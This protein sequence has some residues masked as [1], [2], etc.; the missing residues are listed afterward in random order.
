MTELLR[1]EFS[2]SSY[3]ARPHCSYKYAEALLSL[4]SNLF[5]K[6]IPDENNKC[7]KA[8][9]SLNSSLYPERI[10]DQSQVTTCV[11]NSSINIKV[12]IRALFP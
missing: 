12:T 4:T 10:S 2:I 5:L 8:I 7:T 9:L 11:Q 3:A 6:L 1:V